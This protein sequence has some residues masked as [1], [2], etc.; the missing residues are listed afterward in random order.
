MVRLYAYY[1]CQVTSLGILGQYNA[2]VSQVHSQQRIDQ[3]WMR[4]DTNGL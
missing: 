3:P 2:S 1:N 4:L